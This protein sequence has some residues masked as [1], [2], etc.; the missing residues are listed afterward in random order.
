MDFDE[1]RK[2]ENMLMTQ[3]LA[4]LN[5]PELIQQMANLVSNFPGSEETK[6][7][8]LAEL[9]NQCD[10]DKTYQMYHAIAPHLTFEA[11]PLSFY[12]SRTARKA[13]NMV[14]QRRMRVEG[15]RPGPYRD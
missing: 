10:A 2:L 1:R 13:E 11:E 7:D 6:H 5:D 3:G 8:F 4:G 9:L 12:Q 15:K 14:S